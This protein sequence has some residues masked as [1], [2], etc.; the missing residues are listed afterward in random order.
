M[1]YKL[2]IILIYLIVIACSIATSIIGLLVQVDNINS[3]IPL[4][5]YDISGLVLLCITLFNLIWLSFRG[6]QY[7]LQIIS[8]IILSLFYIVTGIYLIVQFIGNK[9]QFIPK[10]NGIHPPPH[11]NIIL[12]VIFIV[13][14]IFIALSQILSLIQYFSILKQQYNQDIENS[15]HSETSSNRTHVVHSNNKKDTYINSPTNLEALEKAHERQQQIPFTNYLSKRISEQTLIGNTITNNDIN[16]QISRI[17][18]KNNNNK[19]NKNNNDNNN[20]NIISNNEESAAELDF[21]LKKSIEIQSFDRTLLDYDTNNWMS[22]GLNSMF[23]KQDLVKAQSSPDLLYKTRFGLFAGRSRSNLNLATSTNIPKLTYDLRHTNSISTIPN[24]N[25]NKS[26]IKSSQNIGKSMPNLRN[27][28]SEGKI[29]ESTSKASLSTLYTENSVNGIS[30]SVSLLNSNCSSNNASRILLDELEQFDN[31]QKSTD[32]TRRSKSTSCINNSTNQKSKQK[33]ISMNGERHFLSQVNESLL[34]SVLKSGESPIMESKRKQ[35]A[36]INPTNNP[37]PPY[38]TIIKDDSVYNL[39]PSLSPVGEVE[40]SGSRKSIDSTNL[41]YLSNEFDSHSVNETDFNGFDQGYSIPPNNK[42]INQKGQITGKSYGSIKPHTKQDEEYPLVLNGLE[43][44]PPSSTDTSLNWKVSRN[45]SGVNTISLDEWNNH[46]EAYQENLNRNG[47]SLNV[48]G[49]S[50]VVS[51][52]NL[53]LLQNNGANTEISGDY[54]LPPKEGIVDNIDNLSD[55]QTTSSSKQMN[56]ANVNNTRISSV[57]RS[58]SAPSLHTFRNLS[59]SS[60]AKLNTQI[61]DSSIISSSV[62]LR[63]YSTPPE[64]YVEEE[65]NESTKSEHSPIKRLWES[66]KRIASSLRRKSRRL[67]A[68]INSESMINSNSHKHSN[69]VIS[70]TLSVKSNVS[71]RSGSPRKSLKSILYTTKSHH[72]NNSSIPTFNMS[73]PTTKLSS[74]LSEVPALS[75]GS[76]PYI[77]EEPIDFWDLDTNPGSERSR[78]S[79]LPSAVIGEYDKEKWRTLKALENQEKVSFNIEA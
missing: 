32:L 59:D 75:V 18:N 41:P 31:N 64:A 5:I 6:Y 2:P 78:I 69:S 70:N 39:G 25:G 72:R 38:N 68:G 56:N 22:T 1:R 53:T 74:E 10:P 15:S 51:D 77:G 26:T 14:I 47:A 13:N 63:P 24:L 7:L 73:I 37:E 21:I 40:D 52:Y 17:T 54:L 55:I 50:H 67:S 71:S 9:F 57:S 28:I 49:L 19:N 33:L 27:S 76:A 8:Y 48:P 35:E 79:S 16:N 60:N 45:A 36:F 46:S 30:R 23:I 11:W 66:P 20:Q 44:I 34:P 58:Y 42:S 4:L 61:P 12:S 3:Y 62:T 65:N 43:R 29:T